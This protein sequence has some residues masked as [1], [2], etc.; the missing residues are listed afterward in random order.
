MIGYAG[1][2]N[3]IQGAY[4]PFVVIRS[5]RCPDRAVRDKKKG[6]VIYCCKL[7]NK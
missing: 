6:D 4:H 5:F 3:K 7:L 1:K 2:G